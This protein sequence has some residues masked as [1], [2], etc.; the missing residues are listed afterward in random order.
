MK[1]QV[2]R[3]GNSLALRIP[4]AFLRE[5]QIEDGE[6]VEMSLSDGKLVIRPVRQ[7]S[8]ERLVAGITPENRH[9]ETD[10]GEAE[11]AETW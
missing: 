4:Q 2:G 9:A 8:L 5:L 6:T 10:W 1:T 11:G 7:L 3:W